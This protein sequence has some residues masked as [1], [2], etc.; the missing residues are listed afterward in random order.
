MEYE[1]GNNAK[2]A[3][4]AREEAINSKGKR[5]II[6]IAALLAV[7]LSINVFLSYAYHKADAL[8]KDLT[9]IYSEN[10]FHFNALTIESFQDKV[11]LGEDFVVYITRPNCPACQNLKAP[12]I[13]LTKDK[14]LKNKIYY[15]NVVFIRRNDEKWTKFKEIYGFEGT[16]TLARF[17][18]GKNISY[19]GTS[20]IEDAERWLMEQSDY[21]G[22]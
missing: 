14:G 15:L 5:T 22:I 11:A 2:D 13:E 18:G 6:I 12:F 8:A 7:S 3:E 9:D 1:V 10:Y 4:I 17:D 16:P 21:F 20:S 19:I